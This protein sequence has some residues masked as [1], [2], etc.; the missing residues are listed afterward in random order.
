MK[1]IFIKNNSGFTL[2][3]LM[4]SMALFVV[5]MTIITGLFGRAADTQGKA[6]G[7]KNLQEGLDYSLSLIKKGAEEAKYQAY[8]PLS[9]ID[10]RCNASCSG[11]DFFC[12]ISSSTLYLRNKNDQCLKYF[13]NTDSNGIQRLAVTVNDLP[14]SPYFTYLTPADIII[15]GLNF[16]ALTSVSAEI[17]TAA[18]TVS[19]A[20]KPINGV[21]VD[22][23]N[24]QTTVAVRPFVCGQTIYDRD[25]F[26]Y[27]TIL[28]GNQCWMAEN[29]RTRTKANGTCVN[30]T[31][32]VSGHTYT[33]NLLPS[34]TT[35]DNGVLTNL[36]GF[37][38]SGRDCIDWPNNSQGDEA[39]CINGYTLY[40]WSAAMDFAPSCDTTNCA[41]QIISP[42]HQGLC[43]VGW[44]IPTNAEQLVLES[45]V[46]NLDGDNTNN[47]GGAFLKATGN[48]GFNAILTGDRELNGSSFDYASDY[49]TFWTS[50]QHDNTNAYFSFV[51]KN[52]STF[53]NAIENKKY[54][55][56]VRCL[57][58]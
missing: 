28:I 58:D 10:S 49:D 47:N 6:V 4:I 52:D 17:P 23:F 11:N 1:N 45:Y 19:I 8:I 14:T 7:A 26:S 43:P 56:I 46:D 18:L 27:K 13:L 44:H 34:C 37:K 30:Q 36:G 57:K 31:T 40:R 21:S 29:L 2:V 38:D 42:Y 55:V 51:Y 9:N 16:S 12:I 41:A 22:N 32:T 3:E 20:G 48:S 25:N 33:T 35:I 54:N 5:I 53:T 24:L 15:T 39:D 50:T